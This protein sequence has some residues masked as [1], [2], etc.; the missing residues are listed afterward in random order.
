MALAKGTNCGFVSSS[1]VADPGG[2]S[3]TMDGYDVAFKDVSP[4]GSYNVTEIGW[5]QDA[6]TTL[7]A[8]YECAIYEN[9]ATGD[10]GNGKAN[11]VSGSIQ[12]GHSITENTAGWYKYTGLSTGLVSD[13][14]Y[15]IAVGVANTG[16]ATSDYT[17][18]AGN[19]YGYK[20]AAGGV[21]T[22]PWGASWIGL[23]RLIAFYAKYEAA[24]G[25]S[26]EVA[27]GTDALGLTEYTAGVNSEISFTTGIEALTIAEYAADVN[28]NINISAGIDTLI[29][30]EYNAVIS[31]GLDVDVS[32][33]VDSLVLT[34]YT[35]DIFIGFIALAVFETENV[36]PPTIETARA[37]KA[38]SVENNYIELT[39]TALVAP[40]HYY[41]LREASPEVSIINW[42][43]YT[44]GI[45]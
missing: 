12:T 34:E 36:S 44:I 17:V 8:A 23:G 28:L 20:N 14:T 26:V 41:R 13:T 21:L 32:A 18:S 3:G 33:G 9:D 22:D 19:R 11:A 37:S 40:N 35:S 31:V 45:T 7:A 39:L 42:C 1:P 15:W 16:S 24:G 27:A 38:L 43:E 10:G 29:I 30:T 2:T 4:S 6:T 5:W 25:G